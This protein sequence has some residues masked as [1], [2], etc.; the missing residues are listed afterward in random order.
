M[1][2][3]I[4]HLRWVCVCAWR[5]PI[6]VSLSVSLCPW[7]VCVYAGIFSLTCARVLF[8]CLNELP[9]VCVCLK[10]SSGRNARVCVRALP[11]QNRIYFS[12]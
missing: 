8:G 6:P 1:C 10:V 3:C 11:L 12:Y 5:V 9:T 7:C 4:V 2:F